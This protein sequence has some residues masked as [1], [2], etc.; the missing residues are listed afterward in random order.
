MTTAVRRATAQDVAALSRL[1]AATFRET[2]ESENTPENM[3][4]YVAEMF[5]SAKQAAEVS[6]PAAV[7]LVAERAGAIDA[8]ELIG[9]VHLAGGPAP[10]EIVGSKPIEI[11]RFYVLRSFHGR[12]VAHALMDA[13]IAAARAN[14]ADTI[15]L[16]VWER[17]AR[18]AAFYAKYGFMRVGQQIFVL[19]ADAQTDWLLARPVATPP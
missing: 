5:S 12:G 11:K 18:A 16:G 3:A 15:W 9:Y 2:Y 8:R 6:D 4:T 7:V 14:G 10:R 13:A 1:A 19:G 17:N